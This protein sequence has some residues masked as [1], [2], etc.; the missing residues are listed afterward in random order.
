MDIDIVLQ[1]DALTVLK[2]LPSDGVDCCITS[3]PYWGLRDYGIKGQL[4]LEGT[5]E[6]YVAKLVEI[7]RE[8]KRVL[9]KEGTLWLNL[10]TSYISEYIESYEYIIRPDISRDEQ[11]QALQAIA[12]ALSSM[13][14]TDE[15]TEQDMQ[16]V[17]CSTNETARPL[18]PKSMPEVQQGVY[19]P[20]GPRGER[21]GEVLQPLLRKVGQPNE[22]EGNSSSDL[23]DMREAIQQIQGG[24]QE[25]GRN[26]ALL[27]SGMLVQLQP[28]GQS[29]SLERGAG[30]PNEPG[31]GE[32]AEDCTGQGRV[33]LPNLPCEQ[34]TGSPPY[35]P[36]R[37][38]PRKEMGCQQRNN[39]LPGLPPEIPLS[40]KRIPRNPVFHG[41]CASS[42]LESITIPKNAI[43][44]SVLHLFQ[45]RHVL[46]PK[47]DAMIPA[48]V[49]LALQDDGWT[50]RQTIC[51]SKPNPMP[52]SIKDR[53][54]KSHEYIFLLTK[55]QKYYFDQKAI[56][57]PAKETS[58]A[59]LARAVSNKNKWLGGANGQT[60]HTMNQPRENYKHLKGEAPGTF[61]GADHLVTSWE[62]NV[63]KR[64]V[65][66]I[67]T[68]SYKGAHF[69]TFPEALVEPMIKAGCPERGI[70]LDPFI[71][72]GT[73]GM[74]AQKLGRNYI[75]IELNPDYVRMAE[76]RLQQK[77]LL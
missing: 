6:E 40:R 68:P 27:Q 74:V 16:G 43:P 33:A 61:G 34:Q 4:G 51:W 3:P 8:V 45:P 21:A 44:K 39:P 48:K 54:T 13:W 11:R 64:S 17:L 7:F 28:E 31:W 26:A 22:K 19:R 63:N 38:V 57:E 70:V 46:K 18:Y 42:G 71:G 5:P 59:R 58:I 62:G 23:S 60:K 66:T 35:I 55:G 32:M 10:D 73:T 65:W 76:E 36:I 2:T 12:Q 9:R 69:A 75:G 1:G 24:D 50:L 14:Q 77:V 56:T 29:L 72:S 20:Q 30:W 37:S 49:A 67:P 25:N 53:C 52:E 47:D 15:P 41:I